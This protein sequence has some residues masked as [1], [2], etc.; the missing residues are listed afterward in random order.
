MFCVLHDLHRS[1]PPRTIDLETEREFPPYLQ[2]WGGENAPSHLRHGTVAKD[3]SVLQE[4]R[5][6]LGGHAPFN[7]LISTQAGRFFGG[8]GS[9]GK[10]TEHA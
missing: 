4:C 9:L 8:F 3:N 1:S 2:K 7:T 5:R 6:V 10:S